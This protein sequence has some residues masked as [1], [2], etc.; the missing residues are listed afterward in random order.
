MAEIKSKLDKVI[1][2]VLEKDDGSLAFQGAQFMYERFLF[3]DEKQLDKLAPEFKDVSPDD[4][5]RVLGTVAA[6]H[7]IQLAK[8]EEILVE[9]REAWANHQKA[10][11]TQIDELQD[12][13]NKATGENDRLKGIVIQAQKIVNTL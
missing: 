7:V 1:V 13:L 10:F 6:A 12:L 2:D 9:E 4:A 11:Q 8:V 3:E 5:K